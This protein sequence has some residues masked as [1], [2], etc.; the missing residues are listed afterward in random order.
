LNVSPILS[1]LIL[2]L[3]QLIFEENH[4]SALM[5][6]LCEALQFSMRGTFI[7]VVHHVVHRREDGNHGNGESLCAL[8]WLGSSCCDRENVWLAILQSKR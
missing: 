1:Y 4:H 6:R 2:K 5:N 7:V 3:L 8:V